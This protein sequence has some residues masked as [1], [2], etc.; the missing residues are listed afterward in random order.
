MTD[1]ALGPR[2]V[3]ELD[4]LQ[5]ALDVARLTP[6]D[7]AAWGAAVERLIAASD[8]A[9]ARLREGGADEGERAQL[10]ALVTDTIKLVVGAPG[11]IA[12]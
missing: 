11:D 10:V 6:R 9:A 4:A 2:G 7:G 3:S 8:R 1:K 5:L 12:V